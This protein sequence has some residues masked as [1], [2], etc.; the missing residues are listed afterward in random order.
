MSEGL[1]KL[2]EADMSQIPKV[3]G[4]GGSDRDRVMKLLAHAFLRLWTRIALESGQKLTM[5]PSQFVVGTYEG[6][7]RWVLNE[8][9]DYRGI[10]QLSL[11]GV[12]RRRYVLTGETYIQKGEERG[13]MVFA[14]EEEKVKDRPVYVNYLVYDAP[15]TEFDINGALENLKLVVPKWLET[16]MSNDD[17]PLWNACKDQLECVGV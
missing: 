13:R 2:V 14:L 17:G 12:A 6:Q 7:M 9:V 3:V 1:S 4:K 5:S 16:I 10:A 11:T 8:T 15:L